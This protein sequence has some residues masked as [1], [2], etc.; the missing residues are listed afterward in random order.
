MR[1]LSKLNK[2][3]NIIGVVTNKYLSSKIDDS[4]HIIV[5][6]DPVSIFFNAFIKYVNSKSKNDTIISKNAKIS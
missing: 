5:V 1:K 2:N 6:N 3:K 4:K